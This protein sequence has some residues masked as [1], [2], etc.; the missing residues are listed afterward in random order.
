MKSGKLNLISDVGKIKVGHAENH[1][2]I[3]GTS[4]LLFDET[5]VA[6]VDIRGGGAGT[7]ETEILSSSALTQKLDAIVLSGGSV[8]GLAAA[9]GVTSQ[10]SANGRG[11]K[12]VPNTP[13]IPLV[14]GAI[15]YDLANG[16]NK[17]W[18]NN[19]P[20]HDLGHQALADLKTEFAL[21]NVG[22]GFGAYAGTHKGGIGSASIDLGDGII[23]GAYVAVNSVGSAYMEDGE[24]F[25]AWAFEIDGEFGG[26]RPDA[27]LESVTNPV[28]EFSK[29]A[30]MGKFN[31]RANTTLAVVAVNAA[32]TNPEAKRIAMM[33]QDGMARAIRPA[34]LPFDGDLV[35]SVGTGEVNLNSNNDRNVEI[36]RIGSAAA[37][38]LARAIARGVYLAK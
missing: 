24:T 31:Q 14:S 25:W 3:T 30:A 27:N 37:D 28:P 10:L 7:R 29:L 8:F 13:D 5:F 6:A 38:C 32:I 34:H 21:G 4:V 23:V 9:D 11:F 19:T 15:L 22:A 36:A 26:K 18:G 35:Y 12:L 1:D 2:I 16:G 17:D 33:A 20:Y